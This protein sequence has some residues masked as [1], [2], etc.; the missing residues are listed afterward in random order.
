MEFVKP[1]L[2]LTRLS[3]KL[4]QVSP[5]ANLSAKEMG[6]LLPQQD[7]AVSSDSASGF[8]TTY[9]NVFTMHKSRIR[10][11]GRSK[12]A[13]HT[14]AAGDAQLALPLQHDECAD[15]EPRVLRIVQRE[16]R[17]QPECLLISGRMADVCAALERMARNERALQA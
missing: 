9:P 14:A 16:P 15:S 5:S 10:S 17:K 3:L 12:P 2:S 11:S 13:R 6:A 8:H 4:F 1:L 7:S